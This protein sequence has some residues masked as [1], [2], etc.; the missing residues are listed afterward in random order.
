MQGSQ[1]AS[2]SHILWFQRFPSYL[3]RD[4]FYFHKYPWHFAHT[5]DHHLS[6]NPAPMFSHSCGHAVV[7]PLYLQQHQNKNGF[8]VPTWQSIGT[9]AGVQSKVTGKA[10]IG[11]TINNQVETAVTHSVL[12]PSLSAA[13]LIS[14]LLRQGW[15]NK[16]KKVWEGI[17]GLGS[18]ITVVQHQK[19]SCP[20][21]PGF[22]TD[23]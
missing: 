9:I 1:N 13:V 12:H 8:S 10:A 14:Q 6:G 3:A 16:K 17:S 11:E 21:N 4:F 23:G 22:V 7:G 20:Q 19:T 2:L 18:Q 5:W 15:G